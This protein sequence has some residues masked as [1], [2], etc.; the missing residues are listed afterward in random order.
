MEGRRGARVAAMLALATT[1]FAC[2]HASGGAARDVPPVVVVDSLQGIVRVVGVEAFPQAVLVLGDSSPPIT[3][4][5][6][7]ALR[8]VAGLRVAVVGER[9][10]ARFTVSRFVVVAANGLPAIDGIVVASGDV[11]T[12]VTADGKRFPLV[13]PSPVLRASIGHRVWISGPLDHEAVAYGIIE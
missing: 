2:Y 13:N 5:G 6:P 11:L 10:G 12:L 4:D 3:L 9:V 1:A 7:P 8:R